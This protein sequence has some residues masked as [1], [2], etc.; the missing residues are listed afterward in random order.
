MIGESQ[1]LNR[2][3]IM[4]PITKRV[5]L[6]SDTLC[7]GANQSAPEIRSPSIRG[8]LRW[9]HRTVIGPGDNTLFGSIAGSSGTASKVVVRVTRRNFSTREVSILP[10]KQNG[11]GSGI[12]IA[13]GEWFNLTLTTRL[14]GLTEAQTDNLHRTLDAWLL[15]GSLGQRATRATGS[16]W[17]DDDS[18][19]VTISAYL[20]QC[21]TILGSSQIGVAVLPTDENAD[22]DKLRRISSDT[23]GG[24]QAGGRPPIADL[25]SMGYPFGCYSPRIPSP[26]KLKVVYLDDRFHLVALWDR[27]DQP[28]EGRDRGM[29][30]PDLRRGV[31]ALKDARKPLGKLLEP[32][33][34]ELLGR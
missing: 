6:L 20:E 14:G 32:V 11:G 10:H 7:H 24:R 26:L 22:P 8:H 28:L 16:V 30:R 13:R 21:R 17:P 27:R 9:W 5:A 19:P 23:I 12:A 33:L 18:A 3:S 4:D 31:T 15:M 34:P 1:S 25:K 2:Y 29:C